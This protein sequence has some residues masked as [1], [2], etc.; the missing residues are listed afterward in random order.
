MILPTLDKVG[1]ATTLP[2]VGESYH[3]MVEPALGLAVAVNVC[4]RSCSHS[5]SS[6]PLM[7]LL[8]AGSFCKLTAVLPVDSQPAVPI[9]FT[10]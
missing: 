1:F 8:G 7:A 3:T 5:N 6:S 4:I 9:L 10:A 2:P